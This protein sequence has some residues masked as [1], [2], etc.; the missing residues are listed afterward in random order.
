[1][2]LV[3]K[4]IWEETAWIIKLSV[5][6][7]ISLPWG[8][9]FKFQNRKTI[10]KQNEKTQKFLLSWCLHL[11]VHTCV[12]GKKHKKMSAICYWTSS[13]YSSSRKYYYLHSL[14]SNLT[15]TL[16]WFNKY[17]LSIQFVPTIVLT[18]V[19]LLQFCPY[20]KIKT[21]YFES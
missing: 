2:S 14:Q 17:L 12:W 21:W 15:N 4:I 10:E 11:C 20:F 9:C 13:C 3:I 7:F 19:K 6:I 18:A 5:V 1:M 8:P 16:N